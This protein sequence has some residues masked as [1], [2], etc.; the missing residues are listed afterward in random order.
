VYENIQDDRKG[1]VLTAQRHMRQR[2]CFTRLTIYRLRQK[3]QIWSHTRSLSNAS[4]RSRHIS[5]LDKF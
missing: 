2:T 5:A 4:R 1:R 3:L